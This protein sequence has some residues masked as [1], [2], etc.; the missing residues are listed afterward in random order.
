[1]AKLR[2]EAQGFCCGCIPLKTGVCLYVVFVLIVST[3]GVC[4][5]GT[6]DTRVF[7]GG[8]ALSVNWWVPIL[9]AFGVLI[10]LGG[11][12]G[13]HENSTPLVRIF[14]HFALFR[15]VMDICIMIVDWNYALTMCEQL[16]SHGNTFTSIRGHFNLA[17]EMVAL[18]STCV[19]TRQW[20]M[21]LNIVDI[22]LSLY[23]IFKTRLWCYEMDANPAYRINL[24]ETRPLPIYTGYT[25]FGYPDEDDNDDTAISRAEVQTQ[26]TTMMVT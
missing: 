17:L 3:L 19:E 8:Y 22:G 5:V 18:T 26:R 15:V 21:V 6:E 16:M 24:Q 1:M 9:G 10:S 14:V 25:S 7:V 13:I 23:G 20:Y 11:A 12:L 4:T 2:E